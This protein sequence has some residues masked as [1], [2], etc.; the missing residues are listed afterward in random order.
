MRFIN[1]KIAKDRYDGIVPRRPFVI[2]F[3]IG[4]SAEGIPE[5]LRQQCAK[6]GIECNVFVGRYIRPF[7][8]YLTDDEKNNSRDFF[9]YL[10]QEVKLEACPLV[11]DYRSFENYEVFSLYKKYQKELLYL[12][13]DRIDVVNTAHSDYLEELLLEWKMN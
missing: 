1:G 11:C 4:V 6:Y 3:L 12:R 5:R 2:T 8:Y 10:S 13:G 9:D 7:D